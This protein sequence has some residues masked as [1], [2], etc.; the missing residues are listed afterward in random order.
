MCALASPQPKRRPGRPP[1]VPESACSPLSQLGGLIRQLRVGRGLTLVSLGQLTGYSWQHLGAIERGQ[2]VPSE[3]VVA[4]CEQALAAG[5]G[6]IAIFPAVVREQA[7]RRHVRE[8]ARRDRPRG[9]QDP[10]W[11]ELTAAARRPSTVSGAVVDELEQIT[12]RHRAL[13]HELSSA[14]M[15]FSVEAHLGL[16]A[17]LMR[18]R[19]SEAVRH[20]IASAAAEAAGF[21]AW[22]WLDLG[23][24]FKMGA[25]YEMAASL[26]AEAG[27][28]ALGSYI[29]GYRALAAE[30]S[31]LDGQAVQLAE[32]ALSHAPAGTSRLARSWLSAIAANLAALTGDGGR[33]LDLLG[34]ARDHLDTANGKEDWMYDFDCS[35]LAAYRGQCHLRL[36]QARE[37]VTAF[38]AGLAELPSEHARRG[39]FLAIG[40]AEACL[41]AR[42]PD[43]AI[44]HARRAFMVFAACGSTTGLARVRR[45]GDLLGA[46]GR[47]REAA[48]LGEMFADYVAS[49]A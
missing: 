17:S 22:L 30:A 25:L 42:A 43:A 48:E 10:D 45:F 40:L 36:G 38:E 20:R 29:T 44:H 32:A 6:L 26:L 49:P 46:A 3:D 16:L 15:L 8:A 41:S 23:D 47:N 14:E 31:G 7:S 9:D 4:A 13:Y 11:Q 28:A 18:G 2:V 35:A 5:G 19:Q 37:A 39:A 34:Q 12:D 1:K 24:R 27:D 33:A 21:A